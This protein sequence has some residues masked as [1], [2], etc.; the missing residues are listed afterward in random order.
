MSASAMQGGHNDHSSSNTEC[1]DSC[2]LSC[3]MTLLVSACLTFHVKSYQSDIC[4]FKGMSLSP[5]HLVINWLVFTLQLYHQTVLLW[6]FGLVTKMHHKFMER[7]PNKI[8]TPFDTGT[9]QLPD[10]ILRTFAGGRVK[11]ITLGAC[12]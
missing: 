1:F 4:Y 2:P 10:I 8:Y 12:N 7:L 11:K 9:W 3:H 5:L 6:Q